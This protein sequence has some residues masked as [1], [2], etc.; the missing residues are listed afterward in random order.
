MWFGTRDGLNKFDGYQFKVYRQSATPNSL[1]SNDTRTLFADTAHQRL[2]IGTTSGISCYHSSSDNFS[3][4]FHQSNDT[5]TLSNSSIQS[6]YRDSKNRLWVGTT[7]GLNLMREDEQGFRRYY[8]SGNPSESVGSNNLEV[9][10]ED[11]RGSLLLGTAAGLY[12][13]PNTASTISQFQFK[14]LHLPPSPWPDDI[15]IKSIVEDDR[16][17]LWLGSFNDGVA[18]WDRSTDQLTIY[19]NDQDQN[20]VLSNNKIRAMCLDNNGDLWVGTFTGLDQLKKGETKFAKYQKAAQRNEGLAD[21]SI[22]SLFV[23]DRGSLWIGSYYGGINHFGS[24]FNFPEEFTTVYRLH[25]LVP[26]LIEFRNHRQPNDIQTMVPVVDT[27]R[28]GR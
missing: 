8:L 17:N 7:V 24:P 25:P 20:D 19:R 9:I 28:A 23:D 15:H 21:R 12:V 14:K 2:W 6:I 16:G 1:I 10:V 18:Y 5:T 26:D 13:L 3:N 11:S 22:R 4:Y 27:V